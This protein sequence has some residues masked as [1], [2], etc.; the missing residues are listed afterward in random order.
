MKKIKWYCFNITIGRGSPVKSGKKLKEA[1][2]AY[3]EQFDFIPLP[4]N[5]LELLLPLATLQQA[6]EEIRLI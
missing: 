3:K 2:K 4:D 6:Y 1:R 5:P